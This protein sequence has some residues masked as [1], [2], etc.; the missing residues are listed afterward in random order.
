MGKAKAK[1][2]LLSSTK[3]GSGKSVIA[4]GLFLKLKENGYNP[5]YF[6]PIGDPLSMHPSLKTDKDV[7]VINVVVA[8]KF[9]KEEICPAFLNPA[10]FLDELMPEETADTFARIKDAFHS[11]QNKTDIVLIEGN[12]NGHQFRT[13]GLDDTKWAKEFDANVIICAPIKDDDDLNDVISQYDFF[14]LQGINVSGVILNGINQNA[15][16]RI[17][18]YHKPVLTKMGINVI[19][20]L[21]ES[22][23]LMKPTIAEVLDAVNGKLISGNFVKVK[24]NTVEN[25]IIGA[26][27]AESALNYLRKGVD[28]CVITGGDRNDVALAALETSTKLIIFTGNMEPAPSVVAQADQKGVPLAIAPSDTYTVA[29]KLHNIHVQIQPNEIEL[30]R[31]QVEDYIDWDKIPK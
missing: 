11:M 3:G 10:L 20:G 25:F 21:K 19:G 8:R 5:G 9:S 28:Q 12:H 18:K 7:N 27:G 26:M 13:I 17:E 24:N 16:D 1:P 23:Q 22:R 14:K 4:I 29:E 15:F 2:I 31:K 6:K 30:C